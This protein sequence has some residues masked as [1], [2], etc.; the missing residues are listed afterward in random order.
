M[1]SPTESTKLQRIA[2]QAADYPQRVFTTLA[3]LIDVSALERSFHRLRKDASPGIDGQTAAEYAE[4]LLTN[5]R[6]LHERL[7]TKQYRAAHI[8]R[9]WI[10]KDDGTQ[11]PIGMLVLEDKIVQK[12]V[13]MLLESVF[14]ADFYDGS[15]GFRPGRSAHQALDSLWT[16]TMKS[17]GGW[18]LEVD[19]R[20][21]FDTLDHAHLREVAAWL[22]ELDHARERATRARDAVDPAG[23][24]PYPSWP[25]P[26]HSC[27]MHPK[28]PYPPASSSRW[29]PALRTRPGKSMPLLPCYPDSG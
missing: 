6:D 1:R 13:A 10:P 24:W 23:P 18:I 16:Q 9:V 11:R 3:H 19:I 14:E 17:G 22:V 8:R 15:Y 12:A 20:K 2:S 29:R 28:R 21:F 5:L 7:K 4:D 25:A 27:L 26:D